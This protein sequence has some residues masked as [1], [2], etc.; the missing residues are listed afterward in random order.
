[1]D[2][3]LQDHRIYCD[4]SAQSAQVDNRS[5]PATVCSNEPAWRYQQPRHHAPLTASAHRFLCSLEGGIPKKKKKVCKITLPAPLRWTELQRIFFPPSL[6][7]RKG[8]FSFSFPLSQS[9]ARFFLIFFFYFFSLE[10]NRCCFHEST[11]SPSTN[12]FR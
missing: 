2:S 9:T 7:F 12:E 8:C 3:T 10:R 6:R 11:C 4:L 1:M 5:S